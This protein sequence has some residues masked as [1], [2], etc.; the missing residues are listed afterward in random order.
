MEKRACIFGAVG[1]A[2]LLVVAIVLNEHAPSVSPANLA[3]SIIDS[4]NG[5]LKINWNRYNKYDVS[6]SDESSLTITSP[7]VYHLTG[8]ADYPVIVNAGTNAVKLI[9]DNVAISNQSGPAIACY[10][11][12]DLVIELIGENELSDGSAYDG[13]YDEDVNGAIYSKSDLTFE[14]SGSAIITANYQDAIVGKDDLKFASGSYE[15]VSADDGIRG[16]DS[17]YIVDGKFSITSKE[18]AIK[19]TNA[20][21]AGKGFV[22]I[23]GG[24]IEISSGDDGI[25]AETVLMINGGIIDIKKSYE[26]IESPRIIINDGNISIMASDDGINA[27]S[28]SDNTIATNQNETT[29]INQEIIINGG[30]VYVNAAG[31][32]IDSNGYINFNGGI[33][34]VDGPINNGNGA[35]DATYGVLMTGGTVITVGSSGMAETLGSSS[36]VFNVSVYLTSARKAGT[37]IEIKDSAGSTIIKHVSAKAFSHVAVGSESLNFGSTYSLYL[38]GEA[39]QTFTVEDV[40]TT[41]GTPTSNQAG[42]RNMPQR[43][44]P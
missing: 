22:L 13:S 29:S 14:G 11:A 34:V 12:E 30:S 3:A 41:I 31:D 19:S 23:E 24:D 42:P 27:G 9:L 37:T 40:T 5:D 20:T 33:T 36:S 10:A 26:G 4:D 1:L 2:I 16:K 32:G 21:T 17:V 44:T 7:G 25:H 6:L 15:I 8:A 18:D 28:S 43:M 35:L 38:D 39:Y